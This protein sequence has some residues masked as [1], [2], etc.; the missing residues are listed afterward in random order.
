MATPK[1]KATYSLDEKTVKD[2][3]TMAQ[4]LKIS[5]SEALRRAIRLAAE[6]E[7]PTGSEKLAALDE[8]QRSLDRSGDDLARWAEDAQR[9]RH[10]GYRL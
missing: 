10:G 3:E 8:L 2:L 1:I 4:R 9:L 5:K 6:K 7:I